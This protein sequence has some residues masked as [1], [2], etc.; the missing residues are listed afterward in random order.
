MHWRDYIDNLGCLLKTPNRPRLLVTKSRQMP[1]T[2][3][4][5][6]RLPPYHKHYQ[7]CASVTV[8]QLRLS[9]QARPISKP[10]SLSLMRSKRRDPSAS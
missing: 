10:A 7:R 5:W 4:F 3:G 9:F 8:Y 2:G 6:S 1:N